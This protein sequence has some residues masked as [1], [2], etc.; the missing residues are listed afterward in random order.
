MKKQYRGSSIQT[1]IS[2]IKRTFEY[3]VDDDYIVK[4]PFR[5]ITADRSDSKAMEALPVADMNRFLGML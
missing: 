1:Q 5:R 4:N 3:A 2:L